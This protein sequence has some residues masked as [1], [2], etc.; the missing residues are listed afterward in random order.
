MDRWFDENAPIKM[1]IRGHHPIGDVHP[2]TFHQMTR[3]IWGPHG[4]ARTDV[5]PEKRLKDLYLAEFSVET[6]P[7]YVDLGGRIDSDAREGFRKLNEKSLSGGNA[8]TKGR[9]LFAF[10]SPYYTG[11][12]QTNLGS[13][14]LLTRVASASSSSDE[15]KKPSTESENKLRPAPQTMFESGALHWL[16]PSLR[17]DTSPDNNIAYRRDLRRQIEADMRDFVKQ[18]SKLAQTNVA[19]AFFGR[20]PNAAGEEP[21]SWVSKAATTESEEAAGDLDGESQSID[22]LLEPRAGAAGGEDDDEE[23]DAAGDRNG[24]SGAKPP[25]STISSSAKKDGPQ[26]KNQENGSL[27]GG[28]GAGSSKKVDE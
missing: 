22:C 1:L 13:F 28:R 20:G 6:F 3:R 9:V 7:F 10:S 2:S 4:A 18:G 24:G 23:G 19:F 8:P 14:V 21:W 17:F 25:A 27:S 26:Q 15:G 12:G 16:R 5:D 11:Q